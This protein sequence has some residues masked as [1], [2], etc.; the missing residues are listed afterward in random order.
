MGL[1]RPD[2]R[3]VRRVLETA[4]EK[5]LGRVLRRRHRRASKK[6]LS[7]RHLALRRQ[8]HTP[9][10]EYD[11]PRVCPIRGEDDPMQRDEVTCWRL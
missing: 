6:G 11:P 9:F 3:R 10:R 2:L 1:G 5:V 4:F 8:K 7:R